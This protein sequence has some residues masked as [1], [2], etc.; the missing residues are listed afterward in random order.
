M[1]VT[2]KATGIEKLE[3][4]L[5]GLENKVSSTEPLMAE[6]ANHLYNITSDSFENEKS[7]DGISWNPIKPRKADQTPDKILRD[8]GDMQDSLSAFSSKDEAGIGLNAVAN[9]F[10]YGLV[11]QFGT[12]KAGRNKNV[13]IE[14]RPFL[15][16]DEN[17]KL[18]D[19]VEEELIE[20][21]EEY[22]KV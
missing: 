19:G 21:I 16:I 8:E 22:L 20:I 17:G 14:A 15:P 4:A 12:D 18:Y 10:P 13:T 1:Q 7:P 3:E 9:G 6:L 11:H 5:K 2:I